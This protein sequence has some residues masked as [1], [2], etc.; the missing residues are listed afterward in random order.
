MKLGNMKIGPKLFAGFGVVL[1]LTAALGIVSYL[2]IGTMQD[3]SEV[4][5]KSADL[6]AAMK[7]VRQQEKNYILRGDQ[8][9]IDETNEAVTKVKRLIAEL[10]PMVTI[11]ANKAAIADAKRTIPTYERAFADLQTLT[12]TKARQLSVCEDD[13]RDI[14][15]AIKGSSADQATED[16]MIIQLLAARRAEKNF[17]AREDDRYAADVSAEVN[18]L[19]ADANAAEITGSEKSAIRDAADTY[20]KSFSDYVGTVH[21]F[22]EHTSTEGPLV[23]SGRTV[24]AAATT[25][26]ANAEAASSAAADRAAMYVVVFIIVAIVAGIGVATFVTRSI[27]GP[28]G[29][30]VRVVDDFASGKLA[31]R[32]E[33]TKASGELLEMTETLNKF[34]D[35]LQ[36]IIKDVGRV[37]GM[38]AEGDMTA[39]FEAETP[40]DFS[41]IRDNLDQANMDLSDL[42]SGLQKA[43]QAV[44]AVSEESAASTEEM[45]SGMEQ[46]GSASQ[47]IAQGA[48]NLTEV[49]NNA[50]K[51][52][53]DTAAMFQ[54]MDSAIEES[55][56]LVERGVET[57]Q[58]VGEVS[59]SA[60]NSVDEIRDAITESSQVVGGLNDAVQKIGDV[61]DVIKDI[62]DQTNLLALN[63]A[64]EAARAGEYGR[65][66]AVVAEEVR[67]LAEE[68]RKSTDDIAILAKDIQKEMAD[69]VNSSQGMADK[70][71]EVTETVREAADGA[72]EAVEMMAEITSRVQDVA[73]GSKQ[74]SASIGKVAKG[75]D[76][77]ASTSEEAAS[78]SEET[79]SAV[80]E[81]LAAIEELSAGS[82][83]LSEQA[84]AAMELLDRFKVKEGEF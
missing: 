76:E 32:A 13:A 16:E 27:T 2:Q 54:E 5:G 36:E 18:R 75:A 45:N 30:V 46:I 48:Q 61:T 44:A 21:D 50:V 69:V 12:D 70:S 80:E 56:K 35:G 74:G 23:Q 57:V 78:A 72:A 3:Q 52:L 15:T 39:V 19:K 66:F 26:L 51:E 31:T 67:K 34:G 17:V 49:V 14:E 22:T 7:D 81:Q 47:E 62:A 4:M 64:I 11:A 10:E 58:H 65:G 43:I 82:Q 33:A 38:M 53:K 83:H 73:A 59:G 68:S 28:V 1:I 8:T 24:D 55:S 71:V 40:G 63:A 6:K 20:Q 60:R 79:S 41:T 84:Q 25:L 42:V 77:M 9:S 37:T 29:E